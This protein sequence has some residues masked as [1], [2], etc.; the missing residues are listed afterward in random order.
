MIAKVLTDVAVDREFDYL[1]PPPLEGQVVLGSRVNVSFGHRQTQGYVVRFSATSAHPELKAIESVVGTK[2]YIKESLLKLARW[3]ADYYC[4]PVEL[5][6]QEV[7]PG[8]VRHRQA[9]FKEQLFAELVVQPAEP[10]TPS[11]WTPVSLPASDRARDSAVHLDEYAAVF[12][13]PCTKLSA[14]LDRRLARSLALQVAH[15]QWCEKQLWR[16]SVLAN[17]PC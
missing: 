6:V 17:R 5:A 2:P 11:R 3:M 10:L 1:I 14:F 9:K 13:T 12:L 16:V 4:A 7:L 8:A 15:N